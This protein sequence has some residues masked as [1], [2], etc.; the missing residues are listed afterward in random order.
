MYLSLLH[1]NLSRIG[2]LWVSNPYRVHQRLKIACEG[3]PRLLFRIENTDD[4]MYILVQSHNN[5]NWQAAFGDF[6]VLQGNPEQKE[7][8][9]RLQARRTYRFRLLA[10]PTVKKTNEK[11]GLIGKAR[12]GLFSEQLQYGWLKRKLADAGAELLDWRIIP[13]G[14]QHSRKDP[15]KDSQ[16]QTHYAVLFEGALVVIEPALLKSALESGIGPAKA[17]GFGLLSLAPF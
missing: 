9:P 17:Y 4:G 14:M 10:N 15:A 12:F 11:E 13:R 2:N 6:P 16:S 8:E 7:F 5:P 1:L 3:D